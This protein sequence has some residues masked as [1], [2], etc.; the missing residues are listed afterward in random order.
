MG[1]NKLVGVVGVLAVTG[2]GGG[3]S[4][5][6]GLAEW[7]DDGFFAHAVQAAGLRWLEDGRFNFLGGLIVLVESRCAVEVLLAE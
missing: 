2:G 5:G 4:V 7:S 1:A 6:R 3:V